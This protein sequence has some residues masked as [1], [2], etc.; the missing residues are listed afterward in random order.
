MA[1]AEA[2]KNMVLSLRVSELQVLLGFAGQS[3]FGKKNELQARA[4]NL[5]RRNSVPIKMKIMEL[6]D[7]IQQGHTAGSLNAAPVPDAT[8]DMAARR[9]AARQPQ[10]R[11][12][13]PAYATQPPLP[14]I[15]MPRPNLYPMPVYNPY[16]QPN[17]TQPP[18]VTAATS[19]PL[20]PDV[21]LKKLPFYDVLGVLVKTSSLMPQGSQRPQEANFVFHL[22][23]QQSTD[24]G[25]NRDTRPGSKLDYLN[26]VQVRFCLLDTTTEQDDCFPSGIALKVNGKT[27]TLPAAIPP[28]RPGVEPKRPPRP[29]NVT[30]CVK[31][32]PVVTNHITVQWNPEFGRMFTISA[33]LVK[34]LTADDLLQRLRLR[35]FR[36]TDYTK[37]I[38]K[39]KLNEDQ[40][41][42]IATT[43]LRVSLMCPLMK[44]R[45]IFP[46][47]ATTC[48]HLQC[49]DAKAY[50]NMNERKPT[51]MCPVCSMP[52]LFDNLMLDGY[53]QD[54]LQS[55]TLPED[56]LEIQL[57]QDGSWTAMSVK[58]E[59][60]S[61]SNKAVVH[62]EIIADDV[63]EVTTG[64]QDKEA[65]SAPDKELGAIDLTLSDGEEETAAS[66][67]A[68]P[69]PV[70][71]A[72]NEKSSPAPASAPTPPA[73]SL[74]D[75][76][77]LID[78]T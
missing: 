3:K 5:I 45:M 6:Y 66:V 51:W 18:A 21:K 40:E 23:P 34:K 26:Q 9:N 42:E 27:C 50:L 12:M 73:S 57:L 33:N 48:N 68:D 37:G 28:N 44:T 11:P 67:K 36:P 8:S 77:V 52:C 17:I 70:K 20:C 47:R 78:L 16:Q 7:S 53:F 4:V 64:E 30:N 63:E 14:Q 49:F 15:P 38:I 76:V 58:E 10:L 65:V 55:P 29:V 56:A 59:L 43:S 24:I 13:Y 71:A 69:E 72:G 54:V 19:Y 41:G 1:D 35:G 39:D 32:S 22:T 31:I 75:S 74:G 60:P 46:C 61:S 25:V 2:L 62:S